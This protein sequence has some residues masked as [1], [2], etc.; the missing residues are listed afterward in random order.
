MKKNSD[1]DLKRTTI[2]TPRL[3]VGTSV[4]AALTGA[5]KQELSAAPEAEHRAVRLASLSLLLISAANMLGWWVAL[6]IA[7]GSHSPWHL[8]Y[9]VL[10]GILVYAVDRAML[11]AL[12]CRAGMSAARTR[13]FAL[14]D[15]ERGFNPIIQTFSRVAVSVIISL[16]TASFIELEM[17]HRDIDAFL[18]RR[19]S[20]QNEPVFQAASDRVDA[21]IALKRAEIERLDGEAAAILADARQTDVTAQSAIAAQVATLIAERAALQDRIASLSKELD[22]QTT[23]LGAEEAGGIRCDGVVAFAGTRTKHKVA[24]DL[25]DYAREERANA[26]ARVDEVDRELARLQV[27]S[28]TTSITPEVQQLLD[29]IAV[30]RVQ[31]MADLDELVQDRDLMISKSAAQDAAYAVVPEGLIVR[32]E[33][34]ETLARSSPWLAGRILLVSLSLIVL[35]LAAVFVI[36]VQPPPKSLVLRE[37]LASEIAM[38]EAISKAELAIG[39]EKQSIFSV[40]DITTKAEDESDQRVTSRRQAMKTRKMVSDRIDNDLEVRVGSR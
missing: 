22:C 25:A 26:A 10:G 1:Q 27:P 30:S 19:T 24:G 17:F 35:D 15:Q 13:G 33:A 14:E 7:R 32:G 11:R 28:S 23:N 4:A 37:V 31:T 18:E 5:S 34:L 2:R 3:S 8:P 16:T 6:G 40:R 12:W 20:E 38:Y 36:T 9:A 39:E 29:P 21:Q